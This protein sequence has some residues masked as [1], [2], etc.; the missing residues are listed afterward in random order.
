LFESFKESVER[1][2]HDE[3]EKRRRDAER[4]LEKQKAL[5]IKEVKERRQREKREREEQ[6]RIL[7]EEEERAAR[8]AE[9]KAARD[10]KKREEF[11]ALK[12]IREEERQKALEIQALQE[13]R[14]EEAAKRRA[15]AK[16]AGVPIRGAGFERSDSNPRSA[17]APLPLVGAKMGWR[18]KE[19]LRAEGKE[20]PSTRT[21]SPAGRPSPMGRGPAMERQDS[22]D[23]PIASSSGGPPR[24]NLAG[25]KPSWRDRE[26]AKASSGGDTPPPSNRVPSGGV[27]LSR[28]RSG[29]GEESDTPGP[30]RQAPPASSA[31][32]LKPTAAPGKFVPPH[33]R[34]K[35]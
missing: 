10:E 25:G 26:A 18:E 30:T 13:R 34:N 15:D 4:E 8:E 11:L 7:R 14:A 1:S 27:P 32:S 28:G 29:R 22:N 31:D 5:R 33:L 9:E 3:F 12:A 19:K 2:R 16:A 35:K 20:A 21:E 23:R 24:L 6:E 17:P